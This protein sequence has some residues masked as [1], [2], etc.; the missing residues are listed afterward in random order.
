MFHAIH[1]SKFLHYWPIFGFI[2]WIHKIFL[3]SLYNLSKSLRLLNNFIAWSIVKN[4]NQP[5]FNSAKGQNINKGIK[6]WFFFY[7]INLIL[8]ILSIINLYMMSWF[9]LIKII[10]WKVIYLQF[11]L[12]VKKGHVKC[13]IESRENSILRRTSYRNKQ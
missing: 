6:L 7:I 13:T 4:W 9:I 12:S 5:F 2:F 11:A 10:E 3:T 1:V 8:F